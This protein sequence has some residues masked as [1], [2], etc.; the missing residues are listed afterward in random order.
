MMP[1]HGHLVLA[2]EDC[3]ESPLA[4]WFLSFG[5]AV[6]RVSANELQAAV[7]DASFLIERLGLP[8]LAAAALSRE[9][10][11]QLNPRYIYPL[12]TEILGLTYTDKIDGTK[13]LANEV[14]LEK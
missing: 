8:R 3:A 14:L 11:E 6:R 12:V 9:Q 10:I 2:L 4:R 5:A 7:A 13:E 1:L